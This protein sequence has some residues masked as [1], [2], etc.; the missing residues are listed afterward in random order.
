MTEQEWLQATDPKPMLGFLRGKVSDRKLRLF[1]CGCC[2]SLWHLLA[3]ERSRKAIEVAERFADGQA[4]LRERAKADE[5]NAWVWTENEDSPRQYRLATA[6]GDC[7]SAGLRTR[8]ALLYEIDQM[9][10][11]LS[12]DLPLP[13]QAILLRDVFGPSLFRPITLDSSWLEW[14]DGLLVSMAQRMYDSRDFRDMPVL[15][16]ALEEAG[17]DNADILDHCRRPGEHMRGCWMIDLVLGK[18]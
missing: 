10:W 2:R 3:D 18:S 13:A 15:A 5:A 7:V 14:H 6:V 12:E 8:Q 9:S 17:C 16:D 11:F 1:A 4:T